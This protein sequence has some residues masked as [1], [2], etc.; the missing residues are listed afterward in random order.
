M[1]K[2]SIYVSQTQQCD[3]SYEQISSFKKIKHS[4]IFRRRK[5]GKVRARYGTSIF[6]P[7]CIQGASN[8]ARNISPLD[9]SPSQRPKNSVYFVKQIEK[10][11][12][13]SKYGQLRS[14]NSARTYVEIKYETVAQSR[15]HA[16]CA[17]VLYQSQFLFLIEI[18]LRKVQPF[19]SEDS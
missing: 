4:L 18:L 3:T 19:L 9:R 12:C 6:D 1:P 2:G 17:V 10:A 15:D 11:H 14:Q 13:S 5:E 7:L 8:P 16:D